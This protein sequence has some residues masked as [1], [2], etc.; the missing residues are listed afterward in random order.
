MS[1][2]EVSTRFTKNSDY[3]NLAYGSTFHCRFRATSQVD[4]LE[5]EQE[6]VCSCF[7]HSN[8]R[9]SYVAYDSADWIATL[10]L[11]SQW[12]RTLDYRLV[13]Q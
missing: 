6:R 1:N 11:R 10:V 9:S 4:W 8:L 13:F 5:Q 2:T 3:C 7:T 12:N